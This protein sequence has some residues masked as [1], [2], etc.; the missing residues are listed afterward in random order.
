MFQI[1]MI[2]NK[3]FN[4]INTSTPILGSGPILN[5]NTDNLITEEE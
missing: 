1:Q 2:Y 4:S 5:Q 3:A